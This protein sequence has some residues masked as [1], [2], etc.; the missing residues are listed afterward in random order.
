MNFSLRSG[1]TPALIMNLLISAGRKKLEIIAE[2]FLTLK[3]NVIVCLFQGQRETD[4]L[5]VL[6]LY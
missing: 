6:L 1:G 5:H 4:K 3:I 2:C